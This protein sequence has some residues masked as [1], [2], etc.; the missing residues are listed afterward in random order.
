M[1]VYL[2]SIKTACCSNYIYVDLRSSRMLRTSRMT[3][4][5][6]RRRLHPSLNKSVNPSVGN[7][8]LLKTI[9]FQVVSITKVKSRFDPIGLMVIRAEQMSNIYK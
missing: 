6:V 3:R 1:F 9:I 4:T 7:K 8:E 2:S 5:E